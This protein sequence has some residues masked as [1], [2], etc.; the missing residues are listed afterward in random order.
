MSP[1]RRQRLIDDRSDIVAAI[2]VL[3][4]VFGGIAIIPRQWLA[5]WLIVLNIAW[6]RLNYVRARRYARS[7]EA[8]AAADR[9]F[10]A[11]GGNR[12]QGRIGLPNRTKQSL[13]ARQQ[14]N[15][16]PKLLRIGRG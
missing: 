12:S 14:L 2:F 10:R 6:F 9:R 4:L 3:L 11:A 16:A 15:P 8:E 7:L 13:I 1:F 5:T